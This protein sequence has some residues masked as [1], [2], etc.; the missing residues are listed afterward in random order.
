MGLWSN[1]KTPAWR[2]GN[3]GSTPA[4][5]T[6]F[7]KAAGYG[8]PGRLARAH[9]QGHEGS[10]LT[11]GATSSSPRKSVDQY[12]ELLGPDLAQ[13]FLD[14]KDVL[15]GDGRLLPATRSGLPRRHRLLGGLSLRCRLLLIVR[16][17]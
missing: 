11:V 17:L 1:G 5:S 4:G 10:L 13:Q 6:L 9:L 12:V 14:V 7:Q 8:S 15:Q 3:A 2:A 16:L